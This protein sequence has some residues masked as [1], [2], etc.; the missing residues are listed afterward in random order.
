MYDIDVFDEIL[1]LK[2]EVCWI[3]LEIEFLLLIFLFIVGILFV[4]LCL[5]FFW[6][7]VC[8]VLMY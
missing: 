5:V 2:F 6:F 3:F 4:M 7:G 1:V 8:C